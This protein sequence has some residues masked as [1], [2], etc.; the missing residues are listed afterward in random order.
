MRVKSVILSL[1][2]ALLGALLLF[3]CGGANLGG[4]GD[5]STPS[6]PT[7]SI[8]GYIYKVPMP[9]RLKKATGSYK[10]IYSPSPLDP[11]AFPD[12]QPA[13]GV[14]IQLPNGSWTMTDTNGYFELTNLNLNSLWDLIG[15]I[16]DGSSY[17]EIVFP[18]IELPGESG[19]VAEIHVFPSYE[20]SV[21]GDS[22]DDILSFQVEAIDS[23]GFFTFV[24]SDD[25][26]VTSDN[27]SV[28][29]DKWEY[30]TVLVTV[31]DSLP[32]GST[33]TLTFRLKS[34]PS[35]SDTATIELVSSTGGGS[36]GGG[37]TP[38]IGRTVEGR[39]IDNVN[40]PD[41]YSW[42]TI[43]LRGVNTYDMYEIY[44]YSDGS[45]YTTLP[46]DDY[47]VVVWDPYGG[48]H[49]STNGE[50]EIND[51]NYDYYLNVDTDLTGVEI[52]VQE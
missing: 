26:E 34:N 7:Y 22:W 6:T 1:M 42:Y 14:Q 38:G 2:V 30:G 23:N 37:S 27:P 46:E 41:D 51:L 5:I 12:F 32:S 52:I 44:P 33:V 24:S 17:S 20:M 13:S 31:P 19:S 11:S 10:Y 47:E 45:F 15:T 3:G 8:K 35:I 18:P 4:P 49:S 50:V 39:L 43:E 21:Q 48:Y 36:G 29:I 25:L 40:N 9:S 16:W 28:R